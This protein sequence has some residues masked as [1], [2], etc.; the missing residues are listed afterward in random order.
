MSATT[1]WRTSPRCLRSN[2]LFCRLGGGE[3]FAV[4]LPGST[5]A[6]AY[7][8]ADSLRERLAAAPLP[9]EGDAL[10]MTL[11]AGVAGFGADG[12]SLHEL[13]QA[14]DRRTYAAKR[15]GR[16]QVIARDD[17]PQATAQA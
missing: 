17:K 5:A 6:Q 14:A 11:S 12:Q 1:P 16:N 9:V 8:I 10:C 7:A 3:E 13:M 4:L 15:A 2:D